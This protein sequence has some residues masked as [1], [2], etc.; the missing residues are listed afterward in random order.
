MDNS[1]TKWDFIIIATMLIAMGIM[2]GIPLIVQ[3]FWIIPILAFFGVFTITGVLYTIIKVS[4]NNRKIEELKLLQM[5][6]T[7]VIMVTKP[8]VIETNNRKQLS[9]SKQIVTHYEQ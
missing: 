7:P 8:H 4:N 3:V 1:T 2:L 6:N 9:A 5:K